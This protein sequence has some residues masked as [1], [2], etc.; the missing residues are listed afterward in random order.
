MGKEAEAMSRKSTKI[1]AVKTPEQ[2][3]TTLAKRLLPAGQARPGDF[4]LHDVQ[5]RTEA[6]QRDMMRSEEKKTVRRRTRIEKLQAI[7]TIE[8]HE[9]AACE[10]YAKAHSLGYDTLGITADYGSAGGGAGKVCH[11]AKYQAQQEA[12][13]DYAFARAGIPAFLLPLFER[14]VLQ[15]LSLGEASGAAGRAL[16]KAT[17]EF[18]LAAN[19]LHERVAHVLPITG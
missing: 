4:V 6:Q 7:G 14:V 3:A 5:N 16:V 12:R 2:Q 18:R 1:R 8:R 17:A 13:D 11:L 19:K 9:A 10:W 15:G